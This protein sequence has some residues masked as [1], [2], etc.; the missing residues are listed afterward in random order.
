MGN[1]FKNSLLTWC[2]VT[3]TERFGIKN[4]PRRNRDF[5]A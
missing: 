1:C 3:F 5:K 2:I 4:I